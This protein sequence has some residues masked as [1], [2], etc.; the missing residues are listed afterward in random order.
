MSTEAPNV[1]YLW[2][3][4][5]AKTLE[6]NG[7]EQ[8]VICPGSRST[9]LVYAF[10]R[11]TSVEALSVLD[12]RSAAFFALGIARSS[13]KPVALVCTSGSAAANFFP[14][15]IEA[16]ESGAPL[17]VLT[18]DRPSELRNCVAGQTIDQV[19][20]YGS[21][22]RHYLEFS[23]PE[24][25]LGLLR[26]VRQQS[27]Y[28]FEC[29]AGPNPGPVHL[30]IPFRD[31]LPPILQGGFVPVLSASE[32]DS[33][34]QLPT[35][36]VGSV[37]S[38]FSVD[39]AFASANGMVLVG[40]CN[41]SG[42]EREEWIENVSAFCSH[43]NWPVL[44]DALS[45]IRLSHI[46]FPGM[47]SAYDFICRSSQCPEPPKSVLV[48]GDMPT[49]K[50]LRQWL[51]DAEPEIVVVSNRLRHGDPT[52]S[53]SKDVYHDFSKQGLIPLVEGNDGAYKDLW[54]GLDTA[55][56]ERIDTAQRTIVKLDEAKVAWSMSAH[57]P[58]D[59][60]LC[61]SNS[62]APRDLEFFAAPR[63]SK[64]EVFSSRGAN[65][66][67][68]ILSTALG[69]AKGRK[70]TYLLTGDLALLHD[71][72]GGLIAKNAKIDLT[73][74]VVNNDGGGIFGML[75]VSSCGSEFETYF[76]TPQGIDFRQWAAL[77]GFSYCKP[78]TWQDFEKA[79]AEEA[80]GLRLIEVRTQRPESA[81]DRKGLIRAIIA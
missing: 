14:A 31:P 36:N 45:P 46:S 35:V 40:P 25:D 59:A 49:S 42:E 12:E 28:A 43:L 81:T 70:N 16:S 52:A 57:L 33:F 65:G 2:C 15:V 73:I 67:D 41:L 4:V 26:S 32:L 44:A 68:G 17:I 19:K 7:L 74:V 29:S 21:Y 1:N 55:M 13:G 9:P 76:G 18:A 5:I 10:A 51:A 80:K 63:K 69:V 22:V 23:V 6:S 60:T 53:R 50:V 71:S 47:V 58:V 72:N 11:E 54:G 75:P 61:V 38:E 56:R 37:A 79:V 62:M 24:N 8:V 34:V 30:N 3:S 64:I 66:I 48:I 20:L 39:P 78:S 77:Y 27:S